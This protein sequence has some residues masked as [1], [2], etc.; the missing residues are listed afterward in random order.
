MAD[1]LVP[2]DYYGNHRLPITVGARAYF[3]HFMTI[4]AD[5]PVTVDIRKAETLHPFNVTSQV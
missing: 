1:F 5:R 3:C 2:K 4:D